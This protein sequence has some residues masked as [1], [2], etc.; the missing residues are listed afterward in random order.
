MRPAV[1]CPKSGAGCERDEWNGVLTASLW[2]LLVH[3]RYKPEGSNPHVTRR[4]EGAGDFNAWPEA[5][6]PGTTGFSLADLIEL[7]RQISL[8]GPRLGSERFQHVTPR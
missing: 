8:T 5:V 2:P 7:P 1:D 3:L 4:S 6:I